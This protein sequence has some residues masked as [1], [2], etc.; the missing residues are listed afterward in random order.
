MG[1]PAEMGARRR[2]VKRDPERVVAVR[3]DLDTTGFTYQQWGSVQR[4]KPGDWLVDNEGDV[5]T[6]DAESFATTYA[7]VSR[8]LYVKT[9]PV[10]AVQAEAPGVVETQEGATRYAAG[11]YLVSNREYGSDDYAVS[12]ERFEAMYEP[13]D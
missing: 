4:C 7:P 5:Y 13:L 8:G 11:D 1:Y 10:H 2:Y 6:V 12:R 3:L 9:A